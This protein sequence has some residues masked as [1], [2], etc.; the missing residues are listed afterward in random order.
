[1]DQ[2]LFGE[3]SLTAAAV[4]SA[5]LVAGAAAYV[6]RA[7]RVDRVAAALGVPF[8]AWSV[9]GGVMTEDLR[10]RNRDLDGRGTGRRPP[11]RRTPA[12]SAQAQR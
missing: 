2:G 10:E 6:E 9:F 7:S 12:R 3:R 11:G 8:A 4:D 5:V 1:M